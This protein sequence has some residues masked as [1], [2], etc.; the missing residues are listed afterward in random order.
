M[1]NSLF[2][3]LLRIIFSS[4]NPSTLISLRLANKRFKKLIDELDKYHLNVSLKKIY[5]YAAELNIKTELSD[6]KYKI[7]TTNC[8]LCNC[9]DYKYE[10][11]PPHSNYMRIKK[12]ISV[13]DKN[14]NSEYTHHYEQNNDDLIIEE[15]YTLDEDKFILE[16]H[17][18]TSNDFHIYPISLIIDRRKHRITILKIL[19]L[20]RNAFLS[21]SSD[22]A[23]HTT[24]NSDA[25]NN[26]DDSEND[27]AE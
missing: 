16:Q 8:N 25:S 13:L 4:I 5:Y 19:S 27:S 15:E 11:C 17:I 24:E 14:D 20:I 10:Y 9:A 3:D 7:Y 2:D 12:L 21:L 26:S 6:L 1:L 23:K 18:S 22:I